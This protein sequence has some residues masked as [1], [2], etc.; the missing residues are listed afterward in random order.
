MLTEVE[1]DQADA[2]RAIFSISPAADNLRFSTCEK[3]TRCKLLGKWLAG[4]KAFAV[5]PDECRRSVRIS[6]GAVRN[7]ALNIDLEDVFRGFLNLRAIFC[8][9]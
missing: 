7:A 1:C 3:V 8:L 5:S 6:H 4:A 2:E 9:C